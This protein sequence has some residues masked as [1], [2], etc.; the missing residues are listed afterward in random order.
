MSNVRNNR[1]IQQ[2]TPFYGDTYLPMAQHYYPQWNEEIRI[3]LGSY[4]KPN[5]PK[6]PPNM[7]TNAIPCCDSSR[8]LTSTRSL[9]HPP[10]VNLH[11]PQLTLPSA[12]DLSTQARVLVN[13][14]AK[15]ISNVTTSTI[16]NPQ[17]PTPL[18][19]TEKVEDLGSTDEDSLNPSLSLHER[20]DRYGEQR[21]R[22]FCY[23]EWRS[24][25]FLKHVD[26][27]FDQ[28]GR[29]VEDSVEKEKNHIKSLKSHSSAPGS[30][31][32]RSEKFG[33]IPTYAETTADM[34]HVRKKS[35]CN[36]QTTSGCSSASYDSIP[37]CFEVAQPTSTV[38]FPVR[39]IW[40]KIAA[41]ETNDMEECS[42]TSILGTFSHTGNE[43]VSQW[44]MDFEN[45][46]KSRPWTEHDQIQECAKLLR[47]EA[48][49]VFK[50]W[51]KSLYPTWEHFKTIMVKEFN[52]KRGF[53]TPQAQL[54]RMAQAPDE[55]IHQYHQRFVKLVARIYKS[56]EDPFKNRSKELLMQYMHG[57][58]PIVG[59]ILSTEDLNTL[60]EAHSM[61]RTIERWQIAKTQAEKQEQRDKETKREEAIGSISQHVEAMLSDNHAILESVK[62]TGEETKEA[63]QKIDRILKNTERQFP[64][65]FH[66]LFVG[67]PIGTTRGT[68]C[69]TRMHLCPTC[70][71]EQPVHYP[72]QKVSWPPT[73]T[74]QHRQPTTNPTFRRNIPPRMRRSSNQNT[75][76]SNARI[77]KHRKQN[78]KDNH[79]K[80]SVST[81]ETD[82]DAHGQ[83]TTN[84]SNVK[85]PRAT[86][87]VCQ[88]AIMYLI[89]MIFPCSNA[90]PVFDTTIDANS[91]VATYHTGWKNFSIV[92]IHRNPFQPERNA[93]TS[94][95]NTKTKDEKLG[96]YERANDFKSFHIYYWNS[97]AT[98]VWIIFGCLITGTLIVA[99]CLCCPNKR[100]PIYPLNVTYIH[101]RTPNDER[102]NATP[103]EHQMDRISI[104]NPNLSATS[105]ENIQN[106]V[107]TT[108]SSGKCFAVDDTKGK[109]LI[110]E[111][112]LNGKTC[113]ILLDSGSTT[114]LISKEFADL[115]MVRPEDCGPPT[116]Q[117]YCVNET[118]LDFLA[119]AK[120]TIE[121]GQMKHNHIVNISDKY[122]NTVLLGAEFL[123]K[124]S[125]FTVNFK[126]QYVTLGEDEPDKPLIHIPFVKQSPVSLIVRAKEDVI[127]LPRQ[128]QSVEGK[129]CT[130]G[131]L[132]GTIMIEDLEGDGSLHESKGLHVQ[133]N[134]Q[135]CDI[136]SVYFRVLNP[137]DEE[138]KLYKNQKIGIAHELKGKD[139]IAHINDWPIEERPS[140]KTPIM[141]QSQQPEY[142]AEK[143]KLTIENDIHP[144]PDELKEIN[145]ESSLLSENGKLQL[146][147]ILKKYTS[148]F[149]KPG[150][151]MK[152][153][154]ILE[155][156]IDMVKHDPF[157]HK[158]SNVPMALREPVKK[159]LQ[160]MLDDGVI[161]PSQ[162]EYSSRI[163]VVKK[164]NKNEI[165]ICADFRDLN[166]RIKDNPYPLPRIQT[167]LN[168]IKTGHMYFTKI[169]LWKAFYHINLEEASRKYTSFVTPFGQFEYCVSP[170]GLKTSPSVFEK[171]VELLLSGL[172]HEDLVL[173]IDDILIFSNS[174]DSHLQTIEKVLQRFQKHNIS[175]KINKCEFGRESVEFLG[176]KISGK[177]FEPCPSKLRAIRELPEPKDLKGVQHVLGLFNW[178]RNFIPNFAKWSEPLVNLTRKDIRFEWT[179]ACANAK[180]K[181]CDLLCSDPILIL[182]NFDGREFFLTTDASIEGVAGGLS[183]IAD[184]DHK[185][186]P[187]GWA[188]KTLTKSQRHYSNPVR[189]CY[190]I[191]W[192]ILEFKQYISQSPI[193]VRTDHIAWRNL[194]YNLVGPPRVQRWS[195]ELQEFT[196]VKIVHVP[197]KK[198]AH[199]DALSRMPLP[200]EEEEDG[201]FTIYDTLGGTMVYHKDC[202]CDDCELKRKTSSSSLDKTIEKFKVAMLPSRPEIAEIKSIPDRRQELEFLADV[203]NG[204]IIAEIHETSPNKPKKCVY[205]HT[206]QFTGNA[207]DTIIDCDYKAN[208][209]PLY[210]G[211]IE[212]VRSVRPIP[213]PVD[214]IRL[215]REDPYCSRIIDY[216][217]NNNKVDITEDNTTLE[218]IRE[219]P[220]FALNDG[221]LFKH[222]SSA[223]PLIVEFPL[224]LVIPK[225]LQTEVLVGCHD[226]L[227]GGGH[228]GPLKTYNNIAMRYW[229]KGLRADVIRHVEHCHICLMKKGK[230]YNPKEELH[231]APIVATRP[232]SFTST[233]IVGPLK[234]TDSGNKYIV[235]FLC[236]YSKYIEAEAIPDSTTETVA[237]SYLN[238]IICR[239]GCSDT[240]YSDRG[241]NYLGSLIRDI[242]EIC[243]TRRKCSIA[244]CPFSNGHVE[245]CQK[246]IIRTIASYVDKNQRNWDTLLNLALLNLRN[247][248]HS[249]TGFT[250]TYLAMGGLTLK[251]PLD[252]GL[253]TARN[254][255]LACE[256]KTT[257][258]ELMQVC[259]H[260]AK[261][262]AE[263]N[264]E[265]AREDRAKYFNRKV[266]VKRFDVGDQ[267]YR[268]KPVQ[269]VA[270]NSKKLSSPFH[271][272]YTVIDLARPKYLIQ[273]SGNFS[274]KPEWAHSTR[275]KDSKLPPIELPSDL[276]ETLK[277][278]KKI[279]RQHPMAEFPHGPDRQR[280]D[281]QNNDQPPV[282]TQR[283]S[284]RSNN[285]TQTQSSITSTVPN[286]T[287]DDKR[288][289]TPIPSKSILKQSKHVSFENSDPLP[290]TFEEGEEEIQNDS[291]VTPEIEDL[292]YDPENDDIPETQDPY[293][294]P[295]Y[296]DLPPLQNFLQSSAFKTNRGRKIIPPGSFGRL[297]TCL[298]RNP[299]PNRRYR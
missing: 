163:V 82:S 152:R 120:V 160:S 38:N 73:R 100:L 193:V 102:D 83:R 172:N 180:Q 157:K 74:Y 198:L 187:V 141:A 208:S 288:P 19:I 61:A 248:V 227:I 90:I 292:S 148:V 197:G 178:Y 125:P 110:V 262:A 86:S 6:P 108:P 33:S 260:Y 298:R 81:S 122:R 293:N 237:R 165:R 226:D 295:S 195:M 232:F 103:E 130:R 255:Y 21:S 69:I 11:P 168:T 5:M 216:L 111:G 250:P 225:S 146:L 259:R 234:K 87:F 241:T 52:V 182:P 161:R 215:Q 219:A 256:D 190:A 127:I 204:S 186:H 210:E 154:D 270:G 290:D 28:N 106:R 20:A 88:L 254:F 75:F 231:T 285:D 283:Y 175:V 72:S 229:W 199:I 224:R 257:L 281:D 243:N 181:L 189:E 251:M 147:K 32:D 287:M 91:S 119:S 244:Y 144:L 27:E 143:S 156:K 104:Y 222:H 131:R 275:L 1:S 109:Q 112:K 166:T 247:T 218:T 46:A 89:C 60:D 263:E 272:P 78:D 138:I 268:H 51:P 121:L 153:T 278:K 133:R 44:L 171:M 191:Y 56:E 129:I 8:K 64:Q 155:H 98:K 291:F 22:D 92:D 286:V 223:E 271:G 107:Y 31:V 13:R 159:E 7:V 48:R 25:D 233:D 209:K 203:K 294:D 299:K 97:T 277:D 132:P 235:T 77:V 289:D 94:F 264:L 267:V 126:E 45:L 4:A 211:R 258:I 30:I 151:R 174:E 37:E 162:S 269:L 15:E 57:L 167:V 118:Q 23:E 185:E 266:K 145:L 217:E 71:T 99:C 54:S 41:S 135:H 67:D 49:S 236:T 238:L 194:K 279:P 200:F 36:E 84:G 12:A 115:C 34:M 123:K 105:E 29:I 280:M 249:S 240:L 42:A 55:T 116:T 221:I 140:S 47:G 96:I 76:H 213:F 150:K 43:S 188:S 207:I 39:A 183:Q 265:K 296:D 93:Y 192:S 9:P 70:H 142:Q 206:L 114:S 62:Q 68:E 212:A 134:V 176:Y 79:W 18:L 16:S 246:D 169:D 220:Q 239:W 65:Q 128:I 85:M 245:R 136:N 196:I 164:P 149:M 170:F 10:F 2:P 95:T 50:S 284:L 297:K 17:A 139:E 253:P 24:P 3:W 201:D 205:R 66:D 53:D 261:E 80:S 59:Q 228:N 214:I 242:C 273:R 179:E 137:H 184:Y 40:E 276:L 35:S 230:G 26:L 117:A 274:D 113:K 202:T 101:R 58:P 252:Q 63:V 282:P 14:A 173:Y 124:N 158:P 177:G